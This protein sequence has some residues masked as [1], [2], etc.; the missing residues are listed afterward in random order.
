MRIEH[1]RLI[2]GIAALAADEGWIR[3]RATV[4]AESSIFEGHFPGFPL[5][6]GVLLVESMAQTSGYLLLAVNGFS[7][8]PFLAEVRTAKL[9]GFVEPGTALSVEGRLEH[10]GS[11]Y[12]V[13]RGRV[14]RAGRLVAEAELRF[15]TMPFPTE[16][17]RRQVEDYARAIGLP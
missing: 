14:E 9:R 17:M 5:M 6:P 2:D 1:F 8:M 11:G 16:A 12:A 15:R 13:T 7:R 4:P 10:E 3:S